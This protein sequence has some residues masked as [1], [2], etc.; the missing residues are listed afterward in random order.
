MNTSTVIGSSLA[1]AKA[2]A[3]RIDRVAVT[4]FRGFPARAF[5]FYA[6][7]NLIVGISGTGKRV[8]ST[9]CQWQSGVGFSTHEVRTVDTCAQVMATV[10]F[11]PRPA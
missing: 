10:P 7:L 9:P 11:D 6:E 5:S 8:P 1:S 2:G 4:N 3:M